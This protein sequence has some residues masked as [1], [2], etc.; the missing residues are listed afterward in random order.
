MV[1]NHNHAASKMAAGQ[2]WVFL[3]TYPETKIKDYCNQFWP[4]N[5][6]YKLTIEWQLLIRFQSILKKCKLHFIFLFYATEIF[7]Y[8]MLRI[9]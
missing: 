1:I 8:A 9:V 5:V 4:L 7:F 6:T 2:Y 3:K